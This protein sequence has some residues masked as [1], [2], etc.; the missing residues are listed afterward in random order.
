MDRILTPEEVGERLRLSSEQ[1]VKAAESGDIRAFQVA[2]QWRFEESALSALGIPC[3]PQ[4]PPEAATASERGLAELLPETHIVP[5]LVAANGPGVV[6]ELA[7]KAAEQGLVT[8]ETWFAGALAEREAML[9]TAVDGGIAF[10]H[11]RRGNCAQV[12]EPFVLLG[13]SSQGVD[14]GAPDG[15]PTRL[16]FVLGL[17][18]DKLHLKWLSRLARLLRSQETVASLVEADDAPSLRAILL[19]EER[20][21]LRF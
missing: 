8:S 14:F 4:V 11:A 3:R 10:L 19:G 5:E 6:Y 17:K 1:V 20:A 12:L 13:R 21:G 2:G 9:S 16:F 15:E 7:A 18:Y